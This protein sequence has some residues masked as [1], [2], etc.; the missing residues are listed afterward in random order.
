MEGE[1]GVE[2]RS[3]V[4][5]EGCGRRCW[6]GRDD[7]TFWNTDNKERMVGETARERKDGQGPV[8]PPEITTPSQKESKTPG[9]TLF[10]FVSFCSICLVVHQ[11][12]SDPRALTQAALPTCKVFTPRKPHGFARSAHS[13]ITLS[14][15]S[16]LTTLF[17]TTT[18]TSP[19]SLYPF[20]ALMFFILHSVFAS[21]VLYHLLVHFFL[22][23]KI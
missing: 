20:P 7:G 9:R 1:C 12:H 15:S 16:F 3:R 14:V 19:H 4:E 10:V 8:G 18:T 21:K 22:P 11:T 17:K 23:T 13:N 5:A 2:W 6:S